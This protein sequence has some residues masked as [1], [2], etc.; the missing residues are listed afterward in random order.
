MA[1]RVATGLVFISCAAQ[2]AAK[3]GLRREHR[4]HAAATARGEP[5]TDGER[6][7]AMEMGLMNPPPHATESNGMNP[8]GLPPV[9]GRLRPGSE[10]HAVYGHEAY[11]AI[12]GSGHDLYLQADGVVFCNIGEAYELRPGLDRKTFFSGSQQSRAAEMG[13]IALTVY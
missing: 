6:K 7:V 4:H 13:V 3:G 1:H 8:L 5:I 2:A 10:A 9:I 12:F 11:M